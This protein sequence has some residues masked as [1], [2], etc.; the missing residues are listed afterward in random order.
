NAGPADRDPHANAGPA[1]GDQHA[2]AGPVDGDQ[3]ANVSSTDPCR[4]RDCYSYGIRDIDPA[5][6][7]DGA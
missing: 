1:D 6:G 4:N 3:H 2:N 7:S 5:S